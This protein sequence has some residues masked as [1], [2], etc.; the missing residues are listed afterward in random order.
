M[1]LK[2]TASD[3]GLVLESTASDEDLVLKSTASDES[4]VLESTAS[5]E[6]LVLELR[7]ASW[8]GSGSASS[9]SFVSDEN[10]ILEVVL[11]GGRASDSLWAAGKCEVLERHY[12]NRVLK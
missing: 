3:E 9:G 2:S 10:E 11:S 7:G 12:L 6:D 1:V 5:D 4:L 8:S